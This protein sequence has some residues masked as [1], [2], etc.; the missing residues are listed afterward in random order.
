M[1]LQTFNNTK[2]RLRMKLIDDVKVKYNISDTGI[3]GIL[4]A[5]GDFRDKVIV[6]FN[7]NKEILGAVSY[8]ISK[9]YSYIEIDHIGVVERSKG[10]GT[11]LMETVFGIAKETKKRSVSLVSNGFANDFYEK[12]GMKRVGNGSTIIY[13][14]NIDY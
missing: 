11:I 13:E 2:S 10:Y 4:S 6:L 14:K 7:D 1:I 8:F 12:L 5:L 3:D 9:K